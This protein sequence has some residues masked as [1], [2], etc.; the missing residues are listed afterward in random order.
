MMQ[1]IRLICELPT[2]QDRYWYPVIDRSVV[3]STIDFDMRNFKDESFI[4]QFLSLRVIRDLKLFSIIDDDREA[5]IEVGAIHDEQGY[6]AVR[7]ALAEHYNLGS[8]SE[9]HTSELQSRG[10]IVCR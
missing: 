4:L 2:V 6:R 1:D 9:E 3:R 7:E 5:P 10:H 8:R